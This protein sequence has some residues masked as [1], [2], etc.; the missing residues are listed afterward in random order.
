[1]EELDEDS[2]VEDFLLIT[3]VVATSTFDD[4]ILSE[5][6]LTDERDAPWSGI[7]L[8][9]GTL[10]V[11]EVEEEVELLVSEVLEDCLV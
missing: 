10:V 1:M 9:S 5:R 6:L 2:L 11:E 3:E 7:K 4:N 8:V